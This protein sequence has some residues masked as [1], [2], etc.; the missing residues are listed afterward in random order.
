M[1][2]KWLL[3]VVLAGWL[4]HQVSGQSVHAVQPDPILVLITCMSVLNVMSDHVP[5]VQ[6]VLWQ[7]TSQTIHA[8]LWMRVPAVYHEH[9]QQLQH[10]LEANMMWQIHDEPHMM[11]V[12]R[13]QAHTCQNS[14]LDVFSMHT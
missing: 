8:W 2:C 7:S 4:I 13:I 11:H 14:L 12:A 6:S 1:A 9:I 10:L 3:G 5:L